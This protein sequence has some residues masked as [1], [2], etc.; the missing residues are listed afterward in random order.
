MKKIL[1]TILVF[2]SLLGFSQDE[3]KENTEITR[4]F[5]F[6]STGA[7]KDLES[8]NGHKILPQ[9]GDWGFGVNASSIIEYFGNAANGEN[10]NSSPGFNSISKNLPTATIW[11]KYFLAADLAWRGGL[12]IYAENNKDRFRVNDDN[13]LNP[14]VG[15]FDVRDIQQFGFTASLGLEK[16]KGNSRIQGV[17]GADV[18][19]HYTSNNRTNIEYGNTITQSNQ[20]PTSTNFGNPTVAPTPALGYRLLEANLGN[21]FE[22][23][24]R[25]FIGVE[26]FFAPKMSI[27][28]EFYYGVSYVSTSETA[29]TFEGYESSTNEVLETSTFT[30]GNRD[31]E[32][33][34]RNTSAAINLFFYF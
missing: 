34:L 33:G 21:D 19:V 5:I 24:L 16:R 1:T 28:G 12:D 8:K 18:Y 6:K 23:G 2:S 29:V 15:V 27:G 4:L 30:K 32:L 20:N 22:M 13:S 9:K 25:G 26:Y 31:I 10:F 7:E 3:N 14:D 11:G 17:Y